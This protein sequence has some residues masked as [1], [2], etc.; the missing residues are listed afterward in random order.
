MGVGR[1]GLAPAEVERH[2]RR[3]VAL[4][5]EVAPA[6]LVPVRVGKAG[7]DL[8]GVRQGRPAG[9]GVAAPGPLGGVVQDEVVGVDDRVGLLDARRG[10]ARAARAVD[11]P[12]RGREAEPD[13]GELLRRLDELHRAQ[14]QPLAGDEVGALA[15]QG[16]RRVVADPLHAG[17]DLVVG[18]AGAAEDLDVPDLDGPLDRVD[19]QPLRRQQ[20]DRQR[21][22]FL[23]GGVGHGEHLEERGQRA[24]AA[25]LLLEAD[26]LGRVARQLA[27]RRVD[28]E[29]RAG[30]DPPVA[31]R[32]VGPQLE[33]ER[34]ER[35]LGRPEP[36]DRQGWENAQLDDG[37]GR[38]PPQRVVSA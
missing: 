25:V 6:H 23:G 20:V 8:R 11:L 1:E 2:R 10:V 26:R 5:V 14:R 17:H 38:E 3:A 29:R 21:L 24:D 34:L 30:D 4:V 31:E 16:L 15:Q 18:L 33:V 35:D 7:V 19:P 36:T 12:R 13:A 32:L 28:A 9:L 22:E 37:H 27:G